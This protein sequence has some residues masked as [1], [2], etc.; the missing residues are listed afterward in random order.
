MKLDAG[1]HRSKNSIGLLRCTEMTL[2]VF[3]GYWGRLGHR[4][5]RYGD[6]MVT[7]YR[8]ADVA[9]AHALDVDDADTSGRRGEDEAREMLGRVGPWR[10]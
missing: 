2:E 5:L 1:D 10:R 9:D 6:K 3:Y 4:G 7:P 8:G